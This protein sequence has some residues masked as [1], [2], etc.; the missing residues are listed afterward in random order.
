MVPYMVVRFLNESGHALDFPAKVGQ[1]IQVVLAHRHV[2]YY[3]ELARLK[4]P[5]A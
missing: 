4:Y 3:A 1:I 5:W 2:W